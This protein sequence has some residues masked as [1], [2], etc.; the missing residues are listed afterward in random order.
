[1]S[2]LYFGGVM[3]ILTLLI[4]IVFFYQN[5]GE[6]LTSKR[7]SSDAG[8]IDTDGPSAN[9]EQDDSN[10][11][12]PQLPN[13][14]SGSHQPGEKGPWKPIPIR[15]LAQ[16]RAGLSGGEG[17]QQVFSLEIS[18][19]NPTIM[20]AG[21]DVS[22]VHKSSDSGASWTYVGGDI[23]AAGG[24]RNIAINPTN[25]DLVVVSC[26]PTLWF[27]G[28]ASGF[29][30]TSNGGTHWKKVLSLK[31]DI[32]S[33]GGWIEWAS[34]SI[35]FASAQGQGLLKSTNSGDTWTEVNLPELNNDNIQ[36]IRVHPD[37]SDILYVASATDSK[38][39]RLTNSGTTMTQIGSGLPA[40]IYY[41]I[42]IFSNHDSNYS[43]DTVYVAAGNQGIYKSTN[44]GVDFSPANGGSPNN[45]PTGLNNFRS[46]SVS[47]V[48]GRLYTALWRSQIYYFSADGGS[49]WYRTTSYD[50][51]NSDGW[52][53]SSLRQ[54]GEDANPGEYWSKPFAPHPTLANVVFTSSGQV[55]V[56]STDGG[57]NWRYSNSGRN[58]INVGWY[59]DYTDMN[60]IDFD[61]TNSNK[62][63]VHSMDNGTFV[64]DDGGVTFRSV[65]IP[66]RYATVYDS[67]GNLIDS[68]GINATSGGRR[69][70]VMVT[71]NGGWQNRQIIISR[72]INQ[73]SPTW[74]QLT[75]TA[76]SY[77][78]H[79]IRFHPQ[80]TNIVYAEN[81]RF[82]NIQADNSYTTL[83]R[84]VR[85]VYPDNGDTI[86]TLYPVD[87][88]TARVERSDDKGKTW[89]RNTYAN[90]SVQYVDIPI[91]NTTM[92]MGKFAVKP[93]NR[94]VLYV[95]ATNYGLYI[96]NG[97]Q[98]SLKGSSSG[99]PNFS[100]AY[101]A[102]DPKNPSNVYFGVHRSHGGAMGVY[103]SSD[104]GNSFSN[105]NGNLGTYFSVYYL[106]VNPTDSSIWLGR[107]DGGIWKLPSL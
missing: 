24:C 44:S 7:M 41:R 27:D 96:I 105:I 35:L 49:N 87:A 40:T 5:C 52:V 72:N 38:L 26:G 9:R 80:N 101:V 79:N 29:Y 37:N 21:V 43:N 94:D 19:S 30:K 22:P 59:I 45:L 61:P 32:Y 8:H 92:K 78:Y 10:H 54:S 58:Q 83:S 4:L 20:Y 76:K 2:G 60:S 68:N 89:T 31:I 73:A 33:A 57:S 97:N 3:R 75:E 63:S 93:G 25:P 11:T 36:M 55:I 13:S 28:A 95:P 85:A 17:M 91:S 14:S 18:K 77:S 81:Y 98:R 69:G 53:I 62:F 23:D 51:K 70:N 99:I 64:T 88:T 15:T 106:N 39:Y 56:K 103:K 6:S 107:A 67:K 65:N 1:M 90:P 46:L 102:I 47:P 84:P 104:G 66:T 34:S 16:K 86:Y 12:D 48:S 82:D 71:T 42:E 50:E 100:W 74:T